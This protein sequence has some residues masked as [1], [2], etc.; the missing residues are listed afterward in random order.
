MEQSLGAGQALEHRLIKALNFY[1]TEA[2]SDKG[3]PNCTAP[4]RTSS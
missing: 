2:Q 3:F 4:D 1:S